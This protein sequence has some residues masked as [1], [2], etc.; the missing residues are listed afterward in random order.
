MVKAAQ[1]PA[2]TIGLIEVPYRGRKIKVPGDRTFAEWTITVLADGDFDL[3]NKFEAWSNRI[4]THRSNISPD[5]TPLTNT[6]DI[7]QD[8]QIFQ[9]DRA[10][11]RLKA[12]NFVGCWPSEVSAIDVN[13]ETTDSLSEF[14][15]TLQ[16]TY[17]E[18]NTTDSFVSGAAPGANLGAGGPAPGGD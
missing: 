4:Q 15:V 11:N 8:W 17:W 16:Y 18:S 1:L 3:R 12:Y 7:F 6:S 14:T 2:S 5:A 9:L 10:G 13:F